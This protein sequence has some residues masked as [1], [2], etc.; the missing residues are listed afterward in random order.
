M[1]TPALTAGCTAVVA[2]L[3]GQTLTVANAG[4]SRAVLCRGGVAVAMSEDH[5]PNNPVEIARIE[6]AGGHV[7]DVSTAATCPQLTLFNPY[8]TSE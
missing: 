2:V 6:K 4:D 1:D 3:R 8:L 7:N 5:K